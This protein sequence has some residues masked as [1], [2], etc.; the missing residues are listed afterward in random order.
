MKGKNPNVE[1]NDDFVTNDLD[2]QVQ[3]FPSNA[4]LFQ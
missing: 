1:N 2:D 3:G 4:T